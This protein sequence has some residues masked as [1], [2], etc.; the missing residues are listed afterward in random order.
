[1]H[2]RDN[3]KGFVVLALQA[4]CPPFL[5]LLALHKHVSGLDKE[6]LISLSVADEVDLHGAR[7]MHR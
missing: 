4:M 6:W 7:N 3:R 5:G 1:M 2:T